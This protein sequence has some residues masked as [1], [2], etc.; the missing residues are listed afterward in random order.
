MVMEFHIGDVVRVDT[1][2]LNS[3]IIKFAITEIKHDSNG[4][5]ATGEG[6]A[7]W[8]FDKLDYAERPELTAKQKLEAEKL[9]YVAHHTGECYAALR[10]V[11]LEA[12]KQGVPDYLIKQ[13]RATAG[14][15]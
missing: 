14:L 13:I 11:E 2:D 9:E 1:L 3:K 10:R 7:W 12:R 15:P 8:H 4:S 6:H 5:Y